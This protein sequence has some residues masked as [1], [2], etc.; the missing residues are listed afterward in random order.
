[1]YMCV[2]V[3]MYVC[4]YV[5]VYM[6]VCI[7]VCMYLYIYNIV[8]YIYFVWMLAVEGALVSWIHLWKHNLKDCIYSIS[9]TVSTVWALYM[10]WVE[11]LF[12]RR[13]LFAFAL[14]ASVWSLWW[15]HNAVLPRV[16]VFAL[17]PIQGVPLRNE[18]IYICVCIYL[19]MYLYIY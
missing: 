8:L 9:P 13:S 11:S 12:I 1:M 17:V 16:T 15:L 5:C 4:L 14:I 3:Y 6:Y 19:C 18:Y 10:D 7:Y 2:Y